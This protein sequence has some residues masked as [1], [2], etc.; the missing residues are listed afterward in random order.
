MPL[1]D[2]HLEPAVRDPKKLRKTAFI[3]V[4]IMIVGGS[5]IFTAYTKWSKEKAKDDRPA[6]FYRITPERDLRML[7]QDGQI[8]D[9]VNLRQSVLAVN[10]ISIR[11]PQ[12]SERAMAVMK[13]L[14]QQRADTK[15]FH[16]VTLMI[17]PMS[18]EKLEPTLKETAE[19]HGMKL[20]QWWLGSNEPNTLHKFIKNQLKSNIYPHEKDGVWSYDPSIVLIDKSGYIRQAVVPQKRG[21]SPYVGTFDFEQAASWDERGVK[22][23]TERNN[24]EELEVLLNATIDKLLAE[25][26]QP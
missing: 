18:A 16:L 9:L 15:N 25:P 17:D 24:V 2:P 14:S 12:A 11:D 10:V 23:G 6:L 4:G 13:R 26:F 7:R 21:G 20:P 5:L 22:T 1:P 3:L 8:K 19:A